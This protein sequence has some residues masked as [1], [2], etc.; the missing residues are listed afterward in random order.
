M[1]EPSVL[2]TPALEAL[3]EESWQRLGNLR[4]DVLREVAGLEEKAS[5]LRKVLGFLEA[6]LEKRNASE[7]E[8]RSAAEGLFAAMREAGPPNGSFSMDQIRSR[9]LLGIVTVGREQ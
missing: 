5:S 2:P 3:S 8:Q 6:V 7:G 1:A 9:L 4:D